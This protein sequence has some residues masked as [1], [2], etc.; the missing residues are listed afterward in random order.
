MEME[1]ELIRDLLLISVHGAAIVAMDCLCLM[2]NM[3]E[4]AHNDVLKLCSKQASKTYV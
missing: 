4:K 3:R 2:Q 1:L